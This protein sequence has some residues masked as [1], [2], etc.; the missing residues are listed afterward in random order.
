MMS[1]VWIKENKR[2]WLHA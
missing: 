1:L 2:I